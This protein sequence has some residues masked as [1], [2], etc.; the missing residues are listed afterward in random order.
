VAH[1]P[2][3]LLL[4]ELKGTEY[5]ADLFK[6]LGYESAAVTQRTYNGV[7]VLSRHPLPIIS[8]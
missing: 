4:Q 5:P 2:D 3:V 7:A 6:A 8:G 1:N